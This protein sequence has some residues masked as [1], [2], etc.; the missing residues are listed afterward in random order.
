[1]EYEVTKKTR[2][3]FITTGSNPACLYIPNILGY[4]HIVSAVFG[5]VITMLTSLL[6]HLLFGYSQPP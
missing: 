5:L 3:S 1:M 4:I 2:G 6:D